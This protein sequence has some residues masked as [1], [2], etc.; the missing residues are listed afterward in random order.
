[1]YFNPNRSNPHQSKPIQSKMICL[2]FAWW[3][4]W[5]WEHLHCIVI[6]PNWPLSYLVM[7]SVHHN[8]KNIVSFLK[9]KGTCQMKTRTS[10]VMSVLHRLVPKVFP[11]F[12][13]KSPFDFG[14]DWIGLA[15]MVSTD[16]TWKCIN[17]GPLT[18]KGGLIRLL[19]NCC[20]KVGGPYKYL[21]N[22]KTK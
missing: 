13:V 19:P 8:R 1:M 4:I 22:V 18:S 10:S 2:M 9:G 20:L 15:D 5:T 7:A 6:S 3:G 12:W 11:E 21:F 16:I 17:L 14:L